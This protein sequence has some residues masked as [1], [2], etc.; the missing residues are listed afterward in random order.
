MQ[1]YW[2][3]SVIYSCKCL[4]KDRCKPLYSIEK[5]SLNQ[6]QLRT[7]DGITPDVTVFGTA[8]CQSYNTLLNVMAELFH[9]PVA[10]HLAEWTKSWGITIYDLGWQNRHTMTSWKALIILEASHVRVIFQ[11][12]TFIEH[13]RPREKVLRCS[14]PNRWL[15]PRGHQGTSSALMCSADLWFQRST[16]AEMIMQAATQSPSTTIK[17][18][19]GDPSFH[20][21]PYGWT[22]Q[23]SF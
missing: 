4:F 15:V 23:M 14:Q 6:T 2:F 13:H 21:Q 8:S 12:V 1:K 20:I 5:T 10:T 16:C 11:A 18:T 3:Y 22:G 9:N 17:G 7:P 19:G